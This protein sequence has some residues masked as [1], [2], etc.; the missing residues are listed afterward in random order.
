VT[1]QG[2][3]DSVEKG[4]LG[5]AR[6]LKLGSL[7]CHPFSTKVEKVPLDLIGGRMRFL[8]RLSH[9]TGTELVERLAR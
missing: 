5:S 8:T 7:P 3:L 9:I 1:A 4:G 2:L 6:F